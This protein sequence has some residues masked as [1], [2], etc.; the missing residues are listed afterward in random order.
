MK[1]T[2]TSTTFAT[3]YESVL[4]SKLKVKKKSKEI[5]TLATEWG[6]ILARHITEK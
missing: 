3:F 2:W 4:L 1:C 5:K 6:K